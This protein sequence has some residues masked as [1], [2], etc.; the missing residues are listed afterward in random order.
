MIS[1]N[2]N[3]AGVYRSEAF[4]KEKNE[5]SPLRTVD[6]YEFEFFKED[7]EYGIL[8]NKKI[9]Y[10]KNTVLISKPGDMRQSKMHFSC[11]FVHV[12][13]LDETV[14]D[15]I[16]STPSLISIADEEKYLH[17]FQNIISAFPSD[18]DT[19]RIAS[20]GWMMILI[21]ELVKDGND[22]NQVIQQTPEMQRNAILSAKTY[23][24]FNYS[25]DIKLQNIA[26]N[27]HMSPNYFHKLFS[28][29][30]GIS[31][32]QYLTNVRI[33]KA[34]KELMCSEST[35]TQIAENCGFN[36]YSYFCTVFKKYCGL[37]PTE[38]R[39]KGS[40]YYKV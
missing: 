7:Y 29:T 4:Y 16:N 37:T 33:E 32:L 19:K 5:L 6:T 8:N 38:F 25:L 22:I 14:C 39:R 36:S 12:D 13:I 10:K 18:T 26:D 23:M 24:N 35:I 27:I 9:G 34:K 20:I 21:S 40:K 2:I 31:P 28:S 30:C 17:I 1:V 3:G 11:Y 15:L